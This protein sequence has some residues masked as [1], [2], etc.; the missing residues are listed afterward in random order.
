MSDFARVDFGSDGQPIE[1]S[2]RPTTTSHQNLD[3]QPTV[4]GRG[5]LTFQGATGSVE[6]TGGQ[7]TQ[8]AHQRRHA[9]GIT[10]T[11]MLRGGR[12]N[13]SGA[14]SDDA[15]V[16]FHGVEMTVAD[17]IRHGMFMRQ[18]DGTVTAARASS[19][20]GDEDGEGG[21]DEGRPRGDFGEPLADQNSEKMMAI[22]NDLASD[23]TL[24][25]VIK[26]AVETT[27]LSEEAVAML[28]TD[29]GIPQEQA[30]VMTDHIRGQFV[31]QASDAIAIY[32]VEPEDVANWA[33]EH[34][35]TA[36][37]AAIR[38]HLTTRTTNA[39]GDLAREFVAQL[40]TMDPKACLAATLP[41]GL[42]VRRNGDT[43]ILSDAIAGWEMD[44]RSAWRQ[45]LI[46]I[47][48]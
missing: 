13:V 19:A 21:D 43:I 31:E 38:N 42:T 33:M 22:A 36:F 44:W 6:R 24:S 29:M 11:G 32:G 3:Q 40:D 39:W 20:E 12:A 23:D 45:N 37:K 25:A 34:H 10:A 28:A 27:E 30:R 4:V 16:S 5:T 7:D 17:G 2:A 14:L 9:G 46:K 18:P 15:M 26:S 35:P 48:R 8:L 41:Q 47:D 1:A